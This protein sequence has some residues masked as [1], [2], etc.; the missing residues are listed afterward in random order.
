MHII[1]KSLFKYIIK[2]IYFLYIFIFFM[3]KSIVFLND[4]YNIYIQ[5]NI[6]EYE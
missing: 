6:N 2:K 5:N 4:S 1:I 3:Y